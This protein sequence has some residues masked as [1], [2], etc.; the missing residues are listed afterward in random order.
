MDFAI[1]YFVHNIRSHNTGIHTGIAIIYGCTQQLSHKPIY[2]IT[3]MKVV[4]MID[5]CSYAF[6]V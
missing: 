5:A 3:C 2:N 4:F 1:P 6:H